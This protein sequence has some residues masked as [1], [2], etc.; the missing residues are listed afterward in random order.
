MHTDNTF[1]MTYDEIMELVKHMK[2]DTPDQIK[3]R[4]EEAMRIIQEE[5]EKEMLKIDKSRELYIQER[6]RTPK[7]Q[8]YFGKVK[9]E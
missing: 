3:E 7:R 2:T 6:A 1:L 5:Y 8:I 9:T 4:Q